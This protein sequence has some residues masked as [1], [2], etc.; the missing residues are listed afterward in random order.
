M[1]GVLIYAVNDCTQEK[2]NKPPCFVEWRYYFYVQCRRFVGPYSV[3][4]RTFN[5]QVV[6]A[7]L[8]VGKIGKPAIG[9]Y[10]SPV[11]VKPFQAVSVLYF[12]GHVEAQSRKLDAECLVR[13]F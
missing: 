7:V 2:Q 8:D 5:L 10:F 1:H 3:G 11:I 13:F 6:V 4:I 12:V 9:T